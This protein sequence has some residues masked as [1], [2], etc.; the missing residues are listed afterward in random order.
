MCPFLCQRLKFHISKIHCY[1]KYFDPKIRVSKARSQRAFMC[2]KKPQY[3]ELSNTHGSCK[4]SS[5]P[6]IWTVPAAISSAR[7]LDNSAFLADTAASKIGK[8]CFNETFSWEVQ[9]VACNIIPSPKWLSH[10][11]NQILISTWRN[12]L[13]SSN[14][15]PKNLQ[16]KI[17]PSPSPRSQ[18]IEKLNCQRPRSRRPALPYWIQP[19]QM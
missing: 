18:V 7:F 6:F 1:R 16:I 14:F 13:Q 11:I 8:K 5:R 17:S 3:C 19:Y 10:S 9:Y 12:Y 15:N 4:N 2:Q